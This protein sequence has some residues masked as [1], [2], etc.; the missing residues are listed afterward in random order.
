MAFNV[1]NFRS[2]LIY[3]GARPNLF[4]VYITFPPG[5]DTGFGSAQAKTTFMA[6]A[7]HLPGSTI[8]TVPMFYFGREVKFPGNRTFPDWTI[9]IINDEDFLIK[10]AFESWMNLMNS[11]AGNI[12][13]PEMLDSL[14]YSVN[15]SV[16]QYGKTGNIIKQ[17]DFVGMFPVDSTPIDLDWGSNDTIEEFTQTLAYQYW[18]STSPTPITDF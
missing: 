13:D 15:A 11:H 2:Q 6:K 9:T 3:D 7:S 4:E 1:N 5:V 14:G 10:N 12:R 18:T 16:V 17:Y 8:G